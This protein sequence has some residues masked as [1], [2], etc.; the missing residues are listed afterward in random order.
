LSLSFSRRLATNKKKKKKKK[1]V[2]ETKE[3]EIERKEIPQ[4]HRDRDTKLAERRVSF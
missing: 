2:P 4:V 1:K 3:R